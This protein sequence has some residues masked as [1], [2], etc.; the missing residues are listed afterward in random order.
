MGLWRVSVVPLAVC[1][2]GLSTG[3]ASKKFVR[4][5]VTEVND[6]VDSLGRSVEQTQERTRRNETRI[7]EV[8]QR[9]QQ[10]AQAAAAA[11]TSANRANETATSAASTASAAGARTDALE[12][13]ARKMVFEV[14]ITESQGGFKSGSGELPDDAKGRLEELIT[15]LKANPNG[16]YIEIEGHTDSRGDEVLNQRLGL[17]RAEA[18]KRFLHEQY[19]I[20]LHKMNTISYGES[21]PAADNNTNEGRAQDRRVVVKVVG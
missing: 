1:A 19:Q 21:K 9:T 13:A 15:N 20:P 6:K 11:Q 16:G 8:D 17:Q 18:V 10:A 5:V 7:A 2:L 4:G 3:C 14:V 12:K